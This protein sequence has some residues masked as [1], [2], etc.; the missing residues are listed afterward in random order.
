MPRG[1]PGLRMELQYIDGAGASSCYTFVFLAVGLSSFTT[2]MT[3]VF[4]VF[5]QAHKHDL[6]VEVS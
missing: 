6:S 4:N 2:T 3:M 5:S 1:G